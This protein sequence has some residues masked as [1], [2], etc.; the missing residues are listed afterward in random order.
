VSFVRKLSG[1]I[2]GTHSSTGTV[3]TESTGSKLSMV[4]RIQDPLVEFAGNLQSKQSK[5]GSDCRL[6]RLQ[7]HPCR[8]VGSYH[9]YVPTWLYVGG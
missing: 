6:W 5:I 3:R 7:K 9:I 2:P 1:R 4:A 8:K